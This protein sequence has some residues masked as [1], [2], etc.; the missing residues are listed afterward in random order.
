[1]AAFFGAGTQTD[2]F[3]VAFRVPN[4]LRDL[5]AE[6]ALSA[7]F[8]PTFTATEHKDGRD[9]AWALGAQVMNALLITLALVT[10]LG[11]V[12]APWLVPL[13]APGFDKVPGKLELT[14]T[15]SR[16]MLPFLLFVALAAAAMGMLN[17]VRR[18]TVPALAPVFLNL[19]MIVAGVALIPVFR[20]AGQPAILAMAV[21]VLV[22]GFLQ[23]AVQVP[24]LWKLGFRP[25]WPPLLTHPGVRRIAALMVPATVGLAATQLNLF[26]NTILASLL[27]EGSVSWLAYAFRL[28]QLPIGVFGVALATVSLPT[29]SRHAV[30]GDRVALRD[31]LAGAVR[32]VF[33]LTLPATFGLLALSEPI[34][35]LLYQ[36]GRFVAADTDR[37]AAAL[38]AYC[39]GLC[40]YAAVKV[41]VPAFYALGDT[42][43][44]V[45]ASF[46]SVAVN[47]SGN[48]LL[49]QSLGHVGLALSTSLTMLFNFGQLSWAMRKKLGRF[50][51]RRLLSTV[52]RTA[53]ASAAMAV[54]LRILVLVTTTWWRG[55][56][57]GAAL[58]VGSGLVAGALLTWALYR[59]FRVAELA[60]LEAA[61]GAVGRSLGG[62]GRPRG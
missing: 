2:A 11:F 49:M 23:F 13:L 48:L 39:L 42:K 21:G 17:A 30:T 37:T 40:A 45:R 51:G 18:F 56:F 31:T 19:G 25:A 4:L 26:V 5:F 3:N 52:A 47:L 9:R 29:V 34:V 53:A 43:T 16:I 27:I 38:A 22:G 54:L 35:R 7:A 44:P 57:G 28:M 6:G 14:I 15:L 12:I 59:A 41:L 61:V 50:E 58:V 8:V 55:S 32:L 33:A 46:L 62:G 10:V 20:Q 1:M 60:D 36:R 24:T